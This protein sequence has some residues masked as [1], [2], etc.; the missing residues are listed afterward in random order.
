MSIENEFLD[1]FDS[2]VIK[3]TPVTLDIDTENSSDQ[4]TLSIGP[5]GRLYT[6]L[7][8]YLINKI[9]LNDTTI[10]E[11][12]EKSKYV[13]HVFVHEINGTIA[14]IELIKN[15]GFVY[16]LYNLNYF[17][18]TNKITIDFSKREDEFQEDYMVFGS[19]F[20]LY[21]LERNGEVIKYTNLCD[22][23]YIARRVKPINKIIDFPSIIPCDNESISNSEVQDMANLKISEVQDMANLKISEVQ[24]MA[25]LK[26]SEKVVI[27]KAEK[28]SECAWA[29]SV[30]IRSIKERYFAILHK[31]TSYSLYQWNN[32]SDKWEN[33]TEAK[34]NLADYKFY[35]HY[36]KYAR[37]I[38]D[39]LESCQTTLVGMEYH[40]LLNFH[41]KY[42]DVYGRD[43]ANAI[44]FDTVNK[45][46]R[47]DFQ[48]NKS[49][50]LDVKNT[51][52][53]LI[54]NYQPIKKKPRFSMAND[55]Y[56]KNIPIT[57][58]RSCLSLCPIFE[59]SLL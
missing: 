51:N 29:V 16:V 25:N 49:V 46:L 35:F 7:K 4:F 32:S 59:D 23:R 19:D 39:L 11:T 17:D 40:V 5:P 47:I 14:W 12:N 48:N 42:K 52:I 34:F 28:E 36:E 54:Y 53:K 30:C 43:L 26:N 9:L 27:W 58:H 2:E 22:K 55:S 38:E 57:K 37:D 56:H 15:H 13:I 3:L 18:E 33:K 1:L 24:D 44:V 45:T 41:R 20:D 8:G 10:W 6:C 50:S 31:N 21:Y